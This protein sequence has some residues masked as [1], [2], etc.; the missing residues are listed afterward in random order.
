[1]LKG[2]DAGSQ[3]HEVDLAP[4][5]RPVLVQQDGLVVF[6]DEGQI[7]GAREYGC[8]LREQGQHMAQIA[9]GGFLSI[10]TGLRHREVND[11]TCAKS[12]SETFEKDRPMVAS[13]S[14]Y[15]KRDTPG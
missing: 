8:Y 1:M 7:L 15:R 14:V 6:G 3:E 13:E 5:A 10:P 2:W 11:T 9:K 4:R 12:R